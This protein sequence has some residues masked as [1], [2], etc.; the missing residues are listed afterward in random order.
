M[1]KE[2]RFLFALF[3]LLELTFAQQFPVRIVPRVSAPAPVNFYNYADETSLNSPVT[4]QIFLNDLTVASRQIRLKTYFEGGNINFTSKDFVLG[5]EPLFIEGGI[6]LTLTNTQLAPYYKLENIQG[7][8]SVVYG[9]PI[10]EGSYNFC[11]EVYDFASGAKLSAKQ[12][13]TVFIF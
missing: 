10:P 12:C 3:F 4:V 9:R 1:K 7:I 11:F 13:A 2:L 6:P 5:S 8:S